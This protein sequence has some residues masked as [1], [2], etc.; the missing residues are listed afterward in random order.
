MDMYNLYSCII[1]IDNFAI[2]A[3]HIEET[4]RY[5]G[6][7]IGALNNLINGDL[8]SKLLAISKST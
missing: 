2:K 3:L 7:N 8:T 4:Y 5:L 6:I 1:S